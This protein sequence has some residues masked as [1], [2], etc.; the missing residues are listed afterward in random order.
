M[1]VIHLV[2]PTARASRVTLEEEEVVLVRRAFQDQVV[3][4]V[5]PRWYR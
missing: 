3:A 4:A 2:E 1:A 5:E